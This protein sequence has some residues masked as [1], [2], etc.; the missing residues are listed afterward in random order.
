MEADAV[1]ADSQAELGRVD[2]LEE[3]YVAGAG[4]GEALD[5]LLNA[6]GDAFVEIGHVSQG[7]LGPFDLHYSSPSRRMASA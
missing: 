5:G 1:V 7:R 6:A 2:I 4:F 3:L